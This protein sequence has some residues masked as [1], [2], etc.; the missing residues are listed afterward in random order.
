MIKGFLLRH[1]N[2]ILSRWIVLVID[3]FLMECA[4]IIAN[5]LRFDFVLSELTIY[6]IR[7]QL[8][9]LAVIGVISILITGSHK[10]LIRHTSQKDIFNIIKVG[11]LT[12]IL[13]ATINY[14]LF[15]FDNMNKRLV[16]G[17]VEYWMLVPNSVLLIFYPIS[18]FLLL[19]FRMFIKLAYYNLTVQEKLNRIH[20]LVY[21]AG[22]EGIGVLQTLAGLPSSPYKVMGF[23]DDHPGKIGKSVQGVP[24]INPESVT[25]EFLQKRE[26]VEI[27]LAMPNISEEKKNVIYERLLDLN[28]AIKSVPPV[29]SWINGE[30]NLHQIRKINIEDLL[31]RDPIRLDNQTVLRE[32]FGKSVLVTGAA[33]SIGQELSRQLLH[34]NP[35]RLILVDQAE[36]PL[37]ELEQELTEILQTLESRS[38]FQKI[39]LRYIVADVSNNDRVKLLMAEEKPH[40]VYHAAAYKHVPLMEAHPLEAIRVNVFGTCNLADAASENGIEKFVMVST[41]KA[42]NPTSIMGATKRLAEIYIQSLNHNPGNK[43]AFITT[44]FGNVLGSNGSVTRTFNKQIQAGGPVT[45]THPEITRYFM[46]IP[47]ACQLVFEAGAMGSGGEIFIFDMGQPVKIVD[48]ARNMIRLSGYT[49]DREI[50]IVYSGL[51]PGEKLY[52]E[53]L[54]DKERTLPTHH[55][56]IMK[57]KVRDYA[58]DEVS[59]MVG[60]MTEPVR[61]GDRRAVVRLLKQFIPEYISNNSIYRTLDL[62]IERERKAVEIKRTN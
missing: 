54:N 27:I 52:E 15:L 11:T 25:R 12:I 14:G 13:L 45:V 10:G 62:D 21:G 32:V 40:L 46:T 35:S 58:F 34:F 3:V 61:N 22:K 33:G 7:M 5:L 4:L 29:E 6:H 30:L 56:K 51:R 43:T 55:P 50:K 37:F 20:V 28:I 26:I 9:M 8:L 60:Y 47:E 48:L 59:R 36:T 1:S 16:I 57:A 49:P 44:R 24:I 17:G 41:D 18:L 42:V 38:Y 19:S 39:S 31:Q 53:L 2:L 23:M